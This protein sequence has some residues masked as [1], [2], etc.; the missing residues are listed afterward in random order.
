MRTLEEAVDDLDKAEAEIKVVLKKYKVDLGM[1]Y[2]EGIALTLTV[3]DQ[4]PSGDWS[5][6]SVECDF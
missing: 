4:Y 1:L 5:V 2:D 3:Q 6:T